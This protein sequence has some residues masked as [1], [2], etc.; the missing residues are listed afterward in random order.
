[1]S[2]IMYARLV[3][4]RFQPDRR[5]NWRMPAT[6]N[7]KYKAADIGMK[8]VGFLLFCLFSLLFIFVFIV[9]LIHE[10]VLSLVKDPV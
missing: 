7:P 6:T 2:R 8:I 9:T 1:M 3:Q 4:Q 10:A 5:S